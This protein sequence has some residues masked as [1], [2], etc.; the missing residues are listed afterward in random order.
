MYVSDVQEKL[1]FLAIATKSKAQALCLLR[2]KHVRN[3]DSSLSSDN[4]HFSPSPTTHSLT[5]PSLLINTSPGLNALTVQFR[6]VAVNHPCLASARLFIVPSQ[7][8]TPSFALARSPILI[9]V[10][11]PEIQRGSAFLGREGLSWGWLDVDVLLGGALP[12]QG[13]GERT[14]WESGSEDRRARL[15]G[16]ERGGGS[17]GSSS[18]SSS[19]SESV[20]G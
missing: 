3:L 4:F 18:S 17:G 9:F 1:K 2:S 12:V 15:R 5:H 13:V 11:V 7:V 19:S 20:V 6:V 16:L 10:C 8:C 14:E